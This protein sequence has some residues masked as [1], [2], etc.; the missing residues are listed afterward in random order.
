MPSVTT[1]YVNRIA[2]SLPPF[3]VHGAF[4][5]FARSLL[6]DQPRVAAIFERMADKAQIERRYSSLQPSTDPGGQ[7]VDA[8]G[9]YTRGRFP[10]TGARMARYEEAARPLAIQAV[11]GLGLSSGGLSRISHVVVTS[12]TGFSAPGIDLQ[13]VEALGL[14]RSVERTMVGF[15][16][17]FAALNALKLARHIV[18]SEP[19]SHVL[20]INIELCT[21]HL[22]ETRSL[23]PVL[24][25][26]LFGDGCAAS[27][28][29]AE[30]RGIGL[31]RFRTVVSPGTGDLITWR[32]RDTGFDMLL[33][34]KVP[35]AVGDALRAEADAILD[36]AKTTDIELWAVHPGGR[37]VLDAAET[38]LGLD[39]RA[40][41]ISREV[42]RDHGNLS[43]A[44]IMFVLKAM[45][46]RGRSG[47]AGCGLAFGPGLTAESLLFHLA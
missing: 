7:S 1:A 32:V 40:L 14:D 31:D 46:E 34:G 47:A 21:L 20:V 18:R 41:D 13:I 23:E 30:P 25:F 12:C 8:G 4:I 6:A 2:T 22:Q 38:A 35:G 39:P 42:L 43:S 45:L 10:G 11:E 15:M 17:C 36:G 16:G 5:E 37:S 24:S 9:F 26:L 3:E 33:S 44:T 29:T 27:L 19:R 28:V